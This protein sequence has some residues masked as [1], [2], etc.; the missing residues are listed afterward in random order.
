[1][2]EAVAQ[3]FKKIQKILENKKLNLENAAVIGHGNRL[4]P[5]IS[6]FMLNLDIQ[7]H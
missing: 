4:N 6:L 5:T 1:M 7:E 2:C 3:I